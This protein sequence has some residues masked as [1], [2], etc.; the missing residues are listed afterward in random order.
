MNEVAVKE[1]PFLRTT[2][3]KCQRGGM[4]CK[5]RGDLAFDCDDS[6]YEIEPDDCTALTFEDGV[7]V[8][9]MQDDKRSCCVEYPFDNELC[10]RELKEAG[11]WKA[12]RK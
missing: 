7:A 11:L 3:H 4:C 8:C 6:G 2:P 5:G 10:E 9:R 12:Y 1:N